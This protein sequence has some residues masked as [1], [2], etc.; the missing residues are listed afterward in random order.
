MTIKCCCLDPR[1]TVGHIRP[2]LAYHINCLEDAE[3]GRVTAF[4]SPAE[5]L[6]H[7]APK[8]LAALK[9]AVALYGK[10]GGPWNVPGDPGGWL[11]QARD[12]IDLADG[13]AVEGDRPWTKPS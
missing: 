4:T 7:A 1:C 6:E 10:T 12:A 11:T 5:R 3:V 13:N 8:L 2:G 9:R